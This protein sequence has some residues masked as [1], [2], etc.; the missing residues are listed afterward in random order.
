MDYSLFGQRRVRNAVSRKYDKG[1]P[2]AEQN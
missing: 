1:T 2:E